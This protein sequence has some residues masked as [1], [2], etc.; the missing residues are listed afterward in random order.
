MNTSYL[1]SEYM[2]SRGLFVDEWRRNFLGLFD[3]GGGSRG[4]VA[5]V[6]EQTLL[7]SASDLTCG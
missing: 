5:G 7:S 3:A 2:C 1:L 6:A 4:I